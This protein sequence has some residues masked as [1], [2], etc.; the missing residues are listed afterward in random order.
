[1]ETYLTTGGAHFALSPYAQR[2]EHLCSLHA[3]QR[4]EFLNGAARALDLR[5]DFQQTLRFAPARPAT[6]AAD[7]EWAIGGNFGETE[8]LIATRMEG[9]DAFHDLFNALIWLDFPKTKALLNRLQVTQ[10]AQER[11]GHLSASKPEARSRQRDQITLFDENGALFVCQD[12]R[13]AGLLKSRDWPALFLSQRG[14]LMRAARLQVFGHGLLQKCLRPFKSMTARAVV[15]S[16]GA[17]ASPPELDQALSATLRQSWPAWPVMPLPINGW[18]TWSHEQDA[19]FYADQAVFRRDR[20]RRLG[21]SAA[22][23][24][25]F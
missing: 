6:K 23:E 2:F 17:D 9:E 19:E 7:Y 12:E 11:Q 8:G 14:E 16:L 4:L 10:I 22:F 15:L 13:L 21:V 25:K 18:P 20:W 3:D 1:M 24:S 5:N